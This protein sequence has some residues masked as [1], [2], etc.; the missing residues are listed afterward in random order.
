MSRPPPFNALREPVA[1]FR[2]SHLTSPLA[3]SRRGPL[4][5]PHV[6]SLRLT[7]IRGSARPVPLQGDR[8]VIGRNPDCDIPIID[9]RASRRHCAIQSDGRGG[10]VVRD[11]GSRNGTKVNDK[12]VEEAPLKPGDVIK[13]GS[14]E[15][16]VEREPGSADDTSAEGLHVDSALKNLPADVLSGSPSASREI[17]WMFELREMLGA[18]PPRD[19]D[20]ESV[21]IIDANGYRSD[22]LAG[23]SDGPNAVR[24]LI[25]LASKAR[26][27]DIHIEPRSEFHHVR[28]RVDG[29][30]VQIL[31]LPRRV[32]E[33]VFGVM[34]AACQMTVAGRDAI[35]EGHF[36]VVFPDRRVEYRVSITPTVQG[37]KLA[38][39]VLDAKW[40]PTSMSDLGMLPYMFERI[41]RL[42]QQES[43]MLLACGPTGSGKTTTLYNAIR[44]IDR[45][46]RNVVTI[47]DPVEYQ[48]DN[49]TQIPVDEAKGNTFGGLLRGVL[50]Q[51]PDVILV[52]EIRDEETARTAM[53]AALTGHLV[54]SS[55]HAKESIAAVFRLLD[56]RVEPYLVAN[57]LDLIVAQRLV[58]VLCEHCKRETQVLPGQAT[59]LGKWLGGKTYIY[60]AVGCARC[61]RTGYRGRR[62][63][64]EMLDFNDELRD[65]VLHNPSIQAIKKVIENQLF[66]TLAQFGWRLVAEG[67]TSLEEVDR[68]A[69]HG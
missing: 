41:Q 49:V 25:Q 20:P 28:M 62:A 37:P 58:R 51:D 29:D 64:F 54:F 26:A 4:Y 53:Q 69:G 11:L 8:I 15:F 40:Q 24:L 61:L 45:T 12:R 23:T 13:V 55:V 1:L 5:H 67:V 50:R 16:L 60:H 36:S 44:T 65:I 38:V 35:Q 27:T 59:R 39:R 10:W 7:P 52:G 2:L 3:T 22:V 48:I 34:R 46:T 66:T 31:D 63:L 68:V 19:A 43:G 18:L 42:C 57:S 56:L 47:E 33:L 6:P 14:H 17:G 32:G 30:M 21:E 9:E